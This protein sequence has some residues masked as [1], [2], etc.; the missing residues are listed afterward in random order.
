MKK[1]LLVFNL[2]LVALIVIFS[3]QNAAAVKVVF[4]MWKVEVSLALLMVLCVGA[5]ILIA[6]VANL[7][8]ADKKKEPVKRQPKKANDSFNQKITHGSEDKN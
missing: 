6:S 1:F 7:F 4:W 3:I 2:I 5:G 8:T